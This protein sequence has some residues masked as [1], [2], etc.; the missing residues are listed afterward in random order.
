MEALH[1]SER[2]FF[3]IYG[4][5][6]TRWDGQRYSFSAE[7]GAAPKESPPALVEEEIMVEEEEEVVAAD[8]PEFER[9]R[10]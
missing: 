5:R 4:L 8:P 7:G 1:V 2:A 3:E 9:A 6:G 10:T